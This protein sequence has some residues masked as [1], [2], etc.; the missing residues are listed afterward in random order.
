MI[1]RSFDDSAVSFRAGLGE[2]TIPNDDGRFLWD[3]MTQNTLVGASDGSIQTKNGKKWV[4]IHTP[5]NPTLRIR[6]E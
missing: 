5:Y 6:I 1:F 4:G 3:E 2:I